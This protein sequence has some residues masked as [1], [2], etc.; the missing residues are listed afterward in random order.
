MLESFL[1]SVAGL[2]AFN[3]FKK[4]SQRSGFPVT[5][6]KFLKKPTIKNICERLLLYLQCV[7]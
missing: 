6:A 7:I 1:N 5:F 3:F 2:R 4:K